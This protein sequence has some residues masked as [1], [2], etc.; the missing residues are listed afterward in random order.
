MNNILRS[1]ISN[2]IKGAT[3]TQRA[4]P[5][6]QIAPGSTIINNN[7]RSLGDFFEHKYPVGSYPLAGRSW[8]ATDLR[9]K[10]FNDLHEIWFELLRERNK[11]LTEKEL[12]KNKNLINPL[13]IKK[14][15]KSMAAIKVVLG[16]RDQLSKSLYLLRVESEKGNKKRVGE[17]QNNIK[18]LNK[19][20]GAVSLKPGLRDLEGLQD[21]L[22]VGEELESNID[23]LV[24]KQN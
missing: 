1:G 17:L 16:E 15:R 23:S 12:N 11:L 2:I 19:L 13:R 20:V 6:A 18:R 14:V 3:Y 4:A 21:T 9:G 24:N 7:T 8:T 5:A 22:K 10:S